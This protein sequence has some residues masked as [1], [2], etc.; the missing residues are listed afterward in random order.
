MSNNTAVDSASTE[1][2]LAH[3]LH[4]LL[5]VS[6]IIMIFFQLLVYHIGWMLPLFIAFPLKV[7]TLIFEYA[8][9]M[10]YPYFEKL[11]NCIHY[12]RLL[13]ML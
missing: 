12:Y 9:T 7:G 13:W 6:F 8:C 5:D 2:I 4:V 3:L 10:L 1:S 11:F